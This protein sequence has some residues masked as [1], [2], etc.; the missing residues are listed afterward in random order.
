M[1]PCSEA[2]TASKLDMADLDDDADQEA[3][4]NQ[5]EDEKRVPI[6]TLARLF[7]QSKRHL[8]KTTLDR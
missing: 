7:P 2:P 6:D 4:A 5:Q 3:N 1:A 8:L